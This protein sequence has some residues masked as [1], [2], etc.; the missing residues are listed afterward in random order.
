MKRAIRRHHKKRMKIKAMRIYPDDPN[1]H[2]L[3]DHLAVCSCWMCRNERS[4]KK[5][6]IIVE[7]LW[8]LAFSKRL[9][10]S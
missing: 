10:P 5:Q 8:E 1:A 9:Q 3:A 7:P 4:P 2:K 6:N